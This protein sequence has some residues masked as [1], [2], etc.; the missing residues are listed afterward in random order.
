MQQA[1]TIQVNVCLN[2]GVCEAKKISVISQ[3]YQGCQLSI[4]IHFSLVVFHWATKTLV[5]AIHTQLFQGLRKTIQGF[6]VDRFR[7][8]LSPDWL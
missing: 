8:D 2:V 4:L 3:E 5:F 7:R 1:E 6:D